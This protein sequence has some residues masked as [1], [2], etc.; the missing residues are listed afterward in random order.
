MLRLLILL[1]LLSGCASAPLTERKLFD[2]SNRSY[3]QRVLDTRAC[4][5]YL[6]GMYSM[7]V[8]QEYF[9]ACMDLRGYKYQEVQSAN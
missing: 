4:T 8:D 3:S 9:D 5:R 7:T 2:P 6:F 1:L